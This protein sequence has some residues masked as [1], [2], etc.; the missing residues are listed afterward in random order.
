MKKELKMSLIASIEVD[1]E[2]IEVDLI[3][4]ERLLVAKGVDA[5]TRAELVR[6]IKMVDELKKHTERLRH[7]LQ[8]YDR[9]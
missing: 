6:I 7:A 8:E 9:L 5:P 4:Y 2:K 1:L 3:S